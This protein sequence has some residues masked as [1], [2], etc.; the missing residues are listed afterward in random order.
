MV[1]SSE[2]EIPQNMQYIDG[3]LVIAAGS[4]LIYAKIEDILAEEEEEF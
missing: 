4:K 1:G 3:Y 2:R